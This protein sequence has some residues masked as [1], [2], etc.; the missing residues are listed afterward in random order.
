MDTTLYAGAAE[1]DITPEPGLPLDGYTARQGVSAGAHDPLLA[2]VLVLRSSGKQAAI[3]ALD[4]LAVSA[5]FARPLRAQLASLLATSPDAIL[6]SASHT[7]CG[8]AG[9]QNWFPP[10]SAPAVNPQLAAMI[11]QRVTAATRH[12]LSRLEP[13]RL[14]AGSGPVAGVGGDRNHCDRAITTP[15]S[16]LRFDRRSG[17]PLAAVLHYAC[18]PTVLGPQTLAYSADFVAAAR[19]R[20][21]AACPGSVCLYLNGA[22][23]DISTRCFRREQSF[24]EAERV[25]AL[26]A[27]RALDLAAAP[28]GAGLSW[29]T[30]TVELPLR[31]LDDRAEPVTP[32]A[33]AGRLAQ[34]QAEGAAIAARMAAAFSGQSAVRAEVTALRVGGWALLAVP[35]EPFSALAAQMQAAA[36][37]ALVIG[38]ANDYLGYFPTQQAVDGRTYEALSSPY[39]ARAL[40]LLQAA[41]ARLL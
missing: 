14:S 31:T 24:A 8:P 22:A 13:A 10:G 39:D 18:H 41:L 1:T 26:L 29:D 6:I 35:G 30:A 27:Q 12:A 15:V 33:G 2:Q 16:A 36:A 19:R 40:R 23:G 28:A 17:E 4:T 7:H 37:Q 5:A 25:G 21:Q 3:V 32:A 9:L 11:T 38:Y 20:W 34:V